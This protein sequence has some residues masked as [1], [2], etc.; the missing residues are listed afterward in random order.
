MVL[1]LMCAGAD[2][3]LWHTV[4]QIDGS[5]LP[6]GDVRVA[7]L[8]ENPGSLDP[9]SFEDVTCTNVG[10][11]LH[12]A[13]TMQNGRVVHTIRR[14]SGTWFPF[15]DLLAAAQAPRGGVFSIAATDV[16]NQLRVCVALKSRTGQIDSADQSLYHTIRNSAGSWK[17]FENVGGSF[18]DV[19]CSSADG[20]L[21]FCGTTFD[22]QGIRMNVLEHAVQTAPSTFTPFGDVRAV[23]IAENP[24]SLDPGAFHQVCCAGDNGD[25]HVCAVSAGNLF[26]TIRRADGTWFPFGDVVSVV[27]GSNPGS[28]RPVGLGSVAC[29]IVREE[30]HVACID[31]A[32][33]IWHT[34]RRADGS[35]FPFGNVTEVVAG[36][37]GPN[38]GPASVVAVAD[39]F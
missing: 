19:A 27:V 8:S 14:I 21:H 1:H 18:A 12:V 32:G 24:S 16:N 26:H 31:A 34:V 11:D 7:V 20:R 25:L 30:L 13:G 33:V 36:A 3:T 6:F 15:G 37:G 22:H 17:P 28:L 5:W 29:A 10:N 2:G 38:P 23:V 39:S 4:R 9:V 35:W